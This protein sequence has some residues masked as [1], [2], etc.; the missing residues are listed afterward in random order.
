LR[1]NYPNI[2][3]AGDVAQTEDP[4]YNSAIL[5]PTWGNAKKQAKIAAKNMTGKNIEYEGTILIQSIKVFEY[6]AIAAGITHSKHNYDE[7]SSVSFQKGSSRKFVMNKDNLIGVLILEKNLNK[8]ELKPLL[9]NGVYQMVNVS[10]YKTD[11]LKENFN[12]KK[13]IEKNTLISENI[14]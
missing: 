9:K 7:I 8:K 4:L 14:I 5:H 1:T 2:Y 10:N 3:A 13:L 6:R 11:L 12:F